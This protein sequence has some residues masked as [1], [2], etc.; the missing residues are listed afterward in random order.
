MRGR[1][2]QRHPSEQ[3]KPQTS[4]GAKIFVETVSGLFILEIPQETVFINVLDLGVSYG[5]GSWVQS[6]GYQVVGRY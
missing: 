4:D 2:N 5:R 3:T 1:K 6:R